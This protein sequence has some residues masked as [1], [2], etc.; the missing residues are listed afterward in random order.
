[1]AGFNFEPIWLGQCI[2][3]YQV[4]MDVGYMINSIYEKNFDKL[5]PANKQLV[6]KIQ[7]EHSLYYQGKDLS[8]MHQ[9][10][11][12]T[13]DI[14]IWLASRFKHYLDYTKTRKYK[15]NINSVWVN[16]MKAHEYNPVHIHKGTL[17]TGLSSVMILKL[18]TDMGPEYSSAH[19]PMNGRLQILGSVTGQFAKSDYSPE[20]KERDLYIFPYDMRHCVYPMTNPQATRRTLS[21]N[22]DVE[23]NPIESRPA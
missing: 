1:M 15:L 2:G 6:G 7:N 13:T 11:M 23:Y 12:L 4:P 8:K 17:F 21:C 16:Q 9:H 5:P 14:L 3:K 18:P 19:I 10:N 20:I 22:V